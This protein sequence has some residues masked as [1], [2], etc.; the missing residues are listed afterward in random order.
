MKKINDCKEYFK[1]IF[2]NCLAEDALGKSIFDSTKKAQFEM[3]CET[4]KFV[5]DEEFEKVK[6]IWTQETLNEFYSHKIA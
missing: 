2:T 5:Y 1:C 6:P 4:L 3:F